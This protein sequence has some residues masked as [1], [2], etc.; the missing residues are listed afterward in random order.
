M[1]EGATANSKDL[2][3][4]DGTFDRVLQKLAIRSC[5]GLADQFYQ[6]SA[7]PV[8]LLGSDRV[9]TGHNGRRRRC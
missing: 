2:I 5:I 8:D 1:L 6:H 3:R 4:G 7:L 9:R